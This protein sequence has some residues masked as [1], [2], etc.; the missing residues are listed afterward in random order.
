MAKSVRLD[1]EEVVR[2]FH[3][4]E[5]PRSSV[6]LRHPL[7]S[8]IVIAIM[9][10]LAGASGPTGIAKWANLK[11]ELLLKVLKLPHGIP[12]KD[13]F[14][15]VL[16]ALKPDAFQACFATWLTALRD[17]AAEATGVERPTLAIDGKTLRRSHDRRR[18]LGALHSVSI[19]ASEFGLSLGQVATAEKSNEI[20]AIPTLLTLVDI[21]GAII[22]IDAMGTQTAIAE[23]IVKEGGD[24][25]L[26]LKGNQGTLHDATIDYIHEQTKTDF[27]GIGARRLDTVEKKHGRI[28]RRTYIQMPAP[29]SLPG[30]AQWKGLLSIGIAFLWSIRDGK[31]TSEVRYFIS[32]LPV[33]VK[34]FAHAVRSH[35]GIEN[36]CHWCL[37]MTYREDESRIRDERFRENFAWLNRLTLSLLKQ[38]PEKDSIA[39]K[40]RACGWNDDYLLQVLTATSC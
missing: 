24:Y 22:T 38:H 17:A 34:Q 10:V 26:A 19:W 5:D 14:R 36:S 18:N 20:T 3:E 23:K 32:S 7:V 9:A 8:V 12:Q 11:A 37:D 6:N 28:E 13:V 25:V 1:V 29:K 27:R 15:R 31:E 35:W 33:K 4:L 21:Q 30:F 40:R 39:M 2:H 16:A